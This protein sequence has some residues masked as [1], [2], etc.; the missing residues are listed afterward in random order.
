MAPRRCRGPWPRPPAPAARMCCRPARARACAAPWPCCCGRAKG[1]RAVSKGASA[2]RP[3]SCAAPRGLRP[4]LLRA[5]KLVVVGVPKAENGKALARKQR[6]WVRALAQV[7]AEIFGVAR[8]V[9]V[10]RRRCDDDDGARGVQPRRGP[11][12]QRRQR[13]GVPALTRLAVQALGNALRRAGLRAVQHQALH[14]V[15]EMRG[16]AGGGSAGAELACVTSFAIMAFFFLSR[17]PRQHGAL[18]PRHTAR[19]TTRPFPAFS[20]PA[21][22]AQR[23]SLYLWNWGIARTQSARAAV[24]RILGGPPTNRW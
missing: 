2:V 20:A 15:R 4:L 16:R 1:G 5:P 17:R 13:R 24:V 11:V 6:L 7:A 8:R 9:A 14:Q 10:A 23:C 18:Y 12:V 3:T 22:T 21:L 19:H